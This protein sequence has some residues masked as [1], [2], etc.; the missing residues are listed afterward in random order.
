MKTNHIF[1]V[2]FWT[3]KSKIKSGAALVYVEKEYL[4]KNY[5]N[6]NERK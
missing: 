2:L 5:K 6:Q 4:K 1:S 3:N